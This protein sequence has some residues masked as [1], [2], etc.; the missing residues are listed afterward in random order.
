MAG[1]Q[2]KTTIAVFI[3]TLIYSTMI[4]KFCNLFSIILV[5]IENDVKP[6]ISCRPRGSSHETRPFL[7]PCFIHIDIHGRVS[8][9][10]KMEGRRSA[11]GALRPGHGHGRVSEQDATIAVSITSLPYSTM[12]Q[13][14]RSFFHF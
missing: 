4:Q 6:M 3:T 2:S 7:L 14:F 12:I 13:M 10:L 5:I 8:G 9:T 11:E 1:S